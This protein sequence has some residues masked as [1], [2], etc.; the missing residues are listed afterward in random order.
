[1]YPIR[2]E[3][4]Y[5][6]SF[7][8]SPDEQHFMASV[9]KPDRPSELYSIPL[10]QEE[11]QLTGVNDKFVS[12]HAISMPEEIQYVTEDGVTVNGW[13]MKPAQMEA[14][15]AYPLIL[16]IHGG[17]HMMYGH[18]YFHEFQ[19]LAAKG[20]AV[21]YINPRKPRLRAGICECSQRRLWG[22]GL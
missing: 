7:S 10:G 2:L 12:E 3:K 14:E 16:N 4:E 20:Y 21:V 6:N 15:T 9:T 11:K 1:M 13:L 8:L 22:K 18:T 19:V 5:I 17:P